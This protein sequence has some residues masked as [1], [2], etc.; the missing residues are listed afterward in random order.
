VHYRY[1][2]IANC[3]VSCHISNLPWYVTNIDVNIFFEGVPNLVD[4]SQQNQMLLSCKI[5][6]IL[7]LYI[8][9][10]GN[11]VARWLRCCVTNRKVAGSIPAGVTGIFH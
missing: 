1:Y 11:T 2:S 6:L 8:L 4:S 7:D 9:L 3:V 5:L 10:L